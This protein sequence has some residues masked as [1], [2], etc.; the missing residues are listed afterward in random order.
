MDLERFLLPILQLEQVTP[1]LMS[2]STGSTA[3]ILWKRCDISWYFCFIEPI[4]SVQYYP[5]KWHSH[6]KHNKQ[7]QRWNHQSN[8]LSVAFGHMLHTALLLPDNHSTPAV[9]PKQIPEPIHMSVNAVAQCDLCVVLVVSFIVNRHLCPA[10]KHT[11]IQTS[12]QASY[13]QMIHSWAKRIREI[14]L[15][16][17]DQYML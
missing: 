14:N 13:L 8:L 2:A 9:L 11:V 15:Y 4:S 10:S 17:R 12:V 5:T 16:I 7:V 6:Q 1:I 3:Y